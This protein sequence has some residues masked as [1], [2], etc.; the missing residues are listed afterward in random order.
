MRRA[1]MRQCLHQP[2][3]N[4]IIVLG[5]LLR[6]ITSYVSTN[7]WVVPCR[8]KLCLF[9]FHAIPDSAVVEQNKPHGRIKFHQD[10]VPNFHN[11]SAQILT[12]SSCTVHGNSW[13]TRNVMIGV[14]TDP[15]KFISKMWSQGDVPFPVYVFSFCIGSSKKWKGK[16]R[17]NNRW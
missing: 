12:S 13:N 3:R 11:R 8:C 5:N 1:W 7:T 17:N 10:G 9:L 15:W 6:L 2:F 16:R 4:Y 14:P